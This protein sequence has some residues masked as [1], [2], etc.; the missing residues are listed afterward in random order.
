MTRMIDGEV[1]A[2]VRPMSA[3]SA[4]AQY[5]HVTKRAEHLAS[6]II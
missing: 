5:I 1:E 2:E 4:L 6:L 3:G